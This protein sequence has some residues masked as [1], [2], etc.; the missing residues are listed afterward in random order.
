MAEYCAIE[1]WVC[2]EMQL[3]S[4]IR[5][6]RE[7]GMVSLQQCPDLHR[8]PQGFQQ[9][10]AVGMEDKRHLLTY[11]VIHSTKTTKSVCLLVLMSLAVFVSVFVCI[12]ALKQVKEA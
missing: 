9:R 12:S 8:S 10:H 5:F 7:V 4:L 1:L 3:V 11:P 2:F 6:E